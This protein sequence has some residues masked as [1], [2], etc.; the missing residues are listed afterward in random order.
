VAYGYQFKEQMM[1]LLADNE[2]LSLQIKND[3][4]RFDD[5]QKIVQMYNAA[6]ES[7]N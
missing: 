3:I 1:G 6:Y 2:A 4:L 5:I 7:G